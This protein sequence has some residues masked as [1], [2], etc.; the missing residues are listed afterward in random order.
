MS[1]IQHPMPPMGTTAGGQRG[2]GWRVLLRTTSLDR[3]PS[4]EVALEW[5]TVPDEERTVVAE[6]ALSG[7]TFVEDAPKG[8]PGGD[9]AK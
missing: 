1:Q 5:G 7:G 8:R 9:D 2:V 3:E 4:V 6:L